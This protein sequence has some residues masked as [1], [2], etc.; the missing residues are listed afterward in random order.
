MAT[1]R[2]GIVDLRLPL[3]STDFYLVGGL[4]MFGTME[5]YDVPYIG[6]SNPN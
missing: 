3:V 4:E 6:N 1:I 2:Y 5:F